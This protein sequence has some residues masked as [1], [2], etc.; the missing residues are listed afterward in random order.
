MFGKIT[1]AIE[2]LSEE[3][4]TLCESQRDLLEGIQRAGRG[5]VDTEVLGQLQRG[6]E[7]LEGKIEAGIIRMESIRGAARAAEARER[8]HADRTEAALEL[9]QGIDG[10]EEGDSFE[11]AG[12][13]FQS[14]LFEGNDPE[15][16][17]LSGVQEGL[18][19][20]SEGATTARTLKR[21][22]RR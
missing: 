11:E 13:A 8:G 22:A 10:S 18:D 2:S 1:R 14:Q 21:D 7:V 15:G 5:D 16:E 17:G 3:V 4:R 6:L 19:L 12:R 20:G 9:A